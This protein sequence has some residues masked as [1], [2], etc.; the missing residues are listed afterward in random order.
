[1]ASSMSVIH[2]FDI[3][4]MISL[5]L[6]VSVFF[7]GYLLVHFTKYSQG[8]H[9]SK[10]QLLVQYRVFEDWKRIQHHPSDDLDFGI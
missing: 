7:F 3:Q 4:G 5:E 8:Q 9:A 6:L 10:W 1:M 2:L